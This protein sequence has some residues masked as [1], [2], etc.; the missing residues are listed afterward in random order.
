M[1]LKNVLMIGLFVGISVF[2]GRYIFD[3]KYAT[4]ISKYNHFKNESFLT[5]KRI[6]RQELNIFLNKVE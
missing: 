5:I 1:R 2:I 6:I 3:R 4:F